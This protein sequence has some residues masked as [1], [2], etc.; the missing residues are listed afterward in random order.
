[1]VRMAMRMQ[2]RT[3]PLPVRR[4]VELE[5]WAESEEYKKLLGGS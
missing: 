2:K 5:R 1:M 4:V 3:H